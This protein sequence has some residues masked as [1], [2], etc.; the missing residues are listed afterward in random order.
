MEPSKVG[1]IIAKQCYKKR[2]RPMLVIGG[3]FKLMYFG[4]RVLP[5]SWTLALT[6]KFMGGGKID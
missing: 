2:T 3:P 6:N 1:A 5:L 4:T